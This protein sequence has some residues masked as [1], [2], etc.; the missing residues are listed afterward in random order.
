M[1]NLDITPTSRRGKVFRVIGTD[2]VGGA[3]VG[4][5]NWEW[6]EG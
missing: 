2:G 5:E 3:R 1:A 6:K 4:F